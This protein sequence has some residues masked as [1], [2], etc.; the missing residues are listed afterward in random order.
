MNNWVIVTVSINDEQNED[1]RRILQCIHIE[2]RKTRLFQ[3][4]DDIIIYLNV[5]FNCFCV[6][7]NLVVRITGYQ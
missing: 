5:V 2:N 7:F 3:V 1:G 6:Q 4:K